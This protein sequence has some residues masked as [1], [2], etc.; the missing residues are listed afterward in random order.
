MV[1]LPFGTRIYV[2]FLM[3]FLAK[4]A[5]GPPIE[6]SSLSFTSFK[7]ASFTKVESP[8]VL[9]GGGDLLA[10]ISFRQ[11]DETEKDARQTRAE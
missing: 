4:I 7:F 2:T 9:A 5:A 11:G 8:V 10:S 3:Q 1:K 6:P